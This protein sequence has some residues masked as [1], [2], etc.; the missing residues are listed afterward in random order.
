MNIDPFD[1][2]RFAVSSLF[3]QQAVNVWYVLEGQSEPLIHQTLD[4]LI[5]CFH[6]RH[7]FAVG[8]FHLV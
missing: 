7:V 3:G 8:D 2:I 4:L 1:C 6:K 5:G